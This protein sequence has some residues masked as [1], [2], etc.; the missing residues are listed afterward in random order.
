MKTHHFI[1][2]LT[3][4]AALFSACKKNDH[5]KTTP[6]TKEIVS[7]YAQK[8]PFVIGSSVTI[9]ELNNSFNQTG[10]IFQTTISNNSGGFELK[11]I[12]LVS[13]YVELKIDGYYYNEILDQTS[14][15]PLTLHAIA[16]VKNINS[17]NVNVLTHLEKS[18]VEYLIK[19]QRLSFTAAKEQAQKEVLAIFGFTP[20]SVSSETLDLTTDAKLLAISCILQGYLSTGDML[21]LMAGISADI[22]EDGKLDNM[23]LGSKLVDNAASIK[24][25]LSEI[26]NNL[27]KKYSELGFNVVLPDFE[28]YVESFITNGLYPETISITYPK[29]GTHG[30]NILSDHVTEMTTSREPVFNYCMKADVPNGYSLKI[31]LKGGNYGSWAFGTN[32]PPV[33]WHKGELEYNPDTKEDKQ[34]F[35]VIESGKTNELP[36]NAFDP[37]G[38]FGQS[39]I[40]DKSYITIEYYE[41]GAVTPT[42]VKTLKLISPY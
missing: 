36:I 13:Q 32:A 22:R 1:F 40:T 31:I 34:I 11:N 26:R 12:E 42:K 15:A 8:G 7:G 35:T 39:L 30:D 29:T 6:I 28:S 41:N 19:Q 20:Q 38:D 16:D 3:A 5:D 4:F 21:G 9:A 23:D 2:V 25:S 33:N 17:V 27:S 10:K 18:R 37:F 14:G 24:F